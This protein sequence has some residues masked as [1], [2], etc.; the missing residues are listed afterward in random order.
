MNDLDK[1]LADR[2]RRF[3]QRDETADTPPFDGVWSAAEQR[4]SESRR[5][6]RRLASVAAIVAGIVVGLNLQKPADEWVFIEM[7]ELL[8][9]THWSAPSDALLPAREFDIYQ[10]MPVLFESTQPAGGTLL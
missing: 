8:G 5:R 10:D 9:S 4:Y 6:Y 3:W 2:L 7:D 1:Q